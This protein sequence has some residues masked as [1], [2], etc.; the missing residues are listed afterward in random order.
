MFTHDTAM[1]CHLHDRPSSRRVSLGQRLL[2]DVEADVPQVLVE[3]VRQTGSGLLEEPVLTDSESEIDV[4]DGRLGVSE[5]HLILQAD[6]NGE[7]ASSRST[8]LPHVRAEVL[9]GSVTGLDLN[10]NLVG[11]DHH[12]VRAKSLNQSRNRLIAECLTKRPHCQMDSNVGVQRLCGQDWLLCKLGSP[13]Q[14]I[15]A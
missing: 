8:R 6:H 1:A 15:F 14:T 7:A 13:V 4:G 10:E 11:W 5:A 9:G 2:V 3:I 12:D